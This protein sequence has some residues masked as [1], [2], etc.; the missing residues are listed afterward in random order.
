[1][2]LLSVPHGSPLCGLEELLPLF[3]AGWGKQ[4]MPYDEL[5]VVDPKA[6]GRGLAGIWGV[7]LVW[8][9]LQW[10]WGYSVGNLV[11][12]QTPRHFL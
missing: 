4:G 2:E 10:Q 9:W 8:W 1:M 5:L 3:S 7:L 11:V 12:E 6:T